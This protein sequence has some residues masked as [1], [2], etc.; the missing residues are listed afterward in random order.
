LNEDGYLAGSD[1]KRG[2]REFRSP[3]RNRRKREHT[4]E[5]VQRALEVVQAL[6]PPGVAARDLRECLMIQLQIL[7]EDDVVCTQIVGDICINCRT[8]FR[9][10]PKAMASLSTKR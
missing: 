7:G 4:L 1:E 9:E 10:S 8:N 2:S 6:D 5:E 3:R